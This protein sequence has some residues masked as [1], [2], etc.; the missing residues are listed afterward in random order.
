MMEWDKGTEM[1]TMYHNEKAK[2]KKKLPAFV[3]MAGKIEPSQRGAITALW[4]KASQITLNGLVMVDYDNIENPGELFNKLFGEKGS[5]VVGTHK[6]LLAHI[7]PSGHGLR[8]V[9][10][11]DVAVGNIAD[12]QADFSQKIGLALDESCKDSSRLSF[13]VCKKN[14]LLLSEEL[15]TYNDPKFDEKFGND[16]RHGKSQPVKEK[17]EPVVEQTKEPIITDFER[18]DDGQ[19]L[20]KNVP[21]DEIINDIEQARGGK[22][23]VGERN[24]F[25]YEV[26]RQDI[27]YIADF[28]A[29]AI[30]A[31]MP[32]YGLSAEERRA[33]IA[34]ALQANRWRMSNILTRILRD[35]N[36][37]RHVAGGGATSGKGIV[38][39]HEKWFRTFKPYF[40][41]PWLPALNSLDDNVKLAGFLAAGAMFGT[42]LSPVRL[43]DFYDGSTW[44]LS[45]MVYIIGMAAS[46]KGVFVELN[47]LIM[48]PL[49]LLDE[50]GRKWEER[51][52][53][54]KEM[55]ATSSKN[56]K[57]DAMQIQHFPIRVLPGTISNAMR[58]K[59]MK[60]AVAVINGEE[61]HLH[62]YIFESELSAKLR[63]EQGSWAGAQD[64]DC[65]SFSNE[66]GGNDYANAQAT[67]G[68]I[69]VNMNQVITGTQDAMNRKITDRNCL[70]GLATRL[71]LFE[72]PD[73]SYKM[74][75]RTIR[76]R[77]K[78]DVDFLR[79]IGTELLKCTSDV[80]LAKQVAVPPSWQH[81]FGKKTSISDA[82]YKW[83]VEEAQRCAETD[84][85]CA[86]YFRRRAPI[87]AARYAVVD[88]I[89]RNYERFAKTGLLTITFKQVLL[90]YHLASYFQEAQMYFFGQKIMN[91]LEDNESKVKPETKKVSK[92]VNVFNSIKDTFLKSE[93]ETAC[94]KN[95]MIDASS[96]LSRWMRSG[97]VSKKKKAGQTIYVKTIHS[98]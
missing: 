43:K 79:N 29:D 67:N 63:S 21:F 87:I 30:F 51:Y 53:E 39:N 89:L 65:K 26:V 64:L 5:D 70:D 83:G 56:Q 78:E 46:G 86:D 13:A 12:N 41:G 85:K 15:F 93:L 98:I 37:L 23:S 38:F 76:V 3:F 52:K 1:Y 82:L 60:D 68:L 80:S 48:E 11:A 33:A 4:R 19:L 6:V 35:R 91:A 10:T 45:F 32:S 74:L 44:R 47:K 77:S 58:Y 36:L 14:L 95:N 72:M 97:Y 9:F 55:R 81:V 8:F 71:V 92:G 57:K 62:C 94:E 7:T 75:D 88:A 50:Q 17:P 61:R 2:D 84:D 18:N 90:A 59:R 22:P 40:D 42:Y 73:S 28:N 16:Y 31:I 20:Y 24:N 25:Y 49:R 27:R 34:S 66:L 54:D 96:L 69:E